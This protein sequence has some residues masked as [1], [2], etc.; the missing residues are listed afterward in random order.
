MTAFLSATAATEPDA[1][2]RYTTDLPG[3]TLPLTEP[4]RQVCAAGTTTANSVSSRMILMISIPP[5]VLKDLLENPFQ[6]NHSGVGAE[7]L[8]G[9][10]QSRNRIGNYGHELLRAHLV[11]ERCLDVGVDQELHARRKTIAR[12]V[13]RQ[14]E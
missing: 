6:C 2:S 5:R 14:N 11:L 3:D 10:R 13:K 1:L 12:C 8:D 4:A 9:H 7:R